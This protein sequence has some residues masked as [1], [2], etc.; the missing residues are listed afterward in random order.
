VLPDDVLHAHGA[1]L[2]LAAPGARGKAARAYKSTRVAVAAVRAALKRSSGSGGSGGGG[3]GGAPGTIFTLPVG[4]YMAH[5]SG[6]YTGAP[7][8]LQAPALAPATPLLSSLLSGASAA[9]R[10]AA[11]SPVLTYLRAS[12]VV[13][14]I[15]VRLPDGSEQVGARRIT[16]TPGRAFIK[17][18]GL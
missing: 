10:Y 14:C 12:I 1:A 4:A 11:M 5:F 16:P 6:G 17:A 3:G 2:A 13:G 18:F 8:P 15:V 9:L 7:P